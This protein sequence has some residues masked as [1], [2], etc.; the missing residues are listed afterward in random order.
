MFL[1]ACLNLCSKRVHKFKQQFQNNLNYPR[2]EPW[3][4]FPC[5]SRELESS[6]QRFSGRVNELLKA[7]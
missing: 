6:I 2:R 3:Q 5:L 1:P 4:L 7:R